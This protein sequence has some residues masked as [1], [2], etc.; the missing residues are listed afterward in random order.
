MKNEERR[1]KNEEL[2]AMLDGPGAAFVRRK[3][4]VRVP[5]L[6]GRPPLRGGSQD[7]GAGRRGG[8][9]QPDLKQVRLLPASCRLNSPPPDRGRGGRGCVRTLRCSSVGRAS[10]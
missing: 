4:W 10:P 5:P 9:L 2:P 8:R 3:K 7:A 6:A 1:M